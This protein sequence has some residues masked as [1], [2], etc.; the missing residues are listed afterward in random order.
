MNDQPAEAT[1]ARERR[2]PLFWAAAAVGWAVI[3]G[4]G[5]RGILG[6]RIDTR[7]AQLARFVVGGALIHDL[8]VAPI[9]ILA[10]V[11]LAR[12]VPGR[13][14]AP[15][16]AALLVTAAVTLFAY[17]LVR[18]FGHATHNPTSEPHNYA[19]NLAVVLGVVWVSTAV[20]IVLRSRQTRLRG[21]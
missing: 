20:A 5:L 11:A 21:P 7:P 2:G 1:P 6:H 14:R 10:G 18:G 12:L 17:P 15:V 4:V 19:A 9:A 13:A 16:Q 3:L 8:L